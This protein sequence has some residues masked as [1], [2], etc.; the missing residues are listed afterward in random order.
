ME[1][2]SFNLSSDD[3]AFRELSSSVFRAIERSLDLGHFNRPLLQN[4]RELIFNQGSSGVSL[5]D[6]CIFLGPRLKR[7]C[8]IPP[9][10]LDGLVIFVAALKARCLAIDDLS[11]SL[12]D[13]PG[14]ANRIVTDLIRSLSS[15]RELSCEDVAC[16]LR[17]LTHLSYLPSLQYLTVRLPKRLAG[18]SFLDS[19]SN[20]LPFIAMRYLRISVA[21]IAD[22]GEFLQVVSSSSGLEFLHISLEDPILPTPEKIHAVFTIM[23]RSI[24]CDTLTTFGLWDYAEFHENTPPVHSLDAHTLS[25]LLQCRNLER[26]TINLSY[27]YAAVDNPLLQEIASA[28]PCLRDISLHARYKARLW[29]SKA[30]LQGL[31]Y[32]AQHCHSLRSVGLQFDVSLP[33]TVMYPDKGIHYESLIELHVCRSH[34]S[35]PL[36]LAT[37]LAKV[38]PNLKLYHYF[39]GW[40]PDEKSPEY[41]EMG[42]RWND[43]VQMLEARRQE[44]SQS[45]TN[46]NVRISSTIKTITHE[47]S[48]LISKSP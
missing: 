42:A 9:A 15:L 43:V 37:F 3:M 38:F 21:S 20:I 32:L 13:D 27:N 30:N 47:I 46:P 5:R 29:H 12:H 7:L 31:S 19:S 25:P 11:I 1:C 45:L 40:S 18:E 17:T 35:D 14:R 24:F 28:W 22:A 2:L 36:A 8:L 16:D 33:A 10:S 6:M 48:K 23:Q 44:L 39:M 34:V 26:V 4:L 41:I